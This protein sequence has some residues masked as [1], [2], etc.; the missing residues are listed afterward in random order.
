MSNHDLFDSL[1][2]GNKFFHRDFTFILWLFLSNRYHII[3]HFLFSLDSLYFCKF[4][5][6]TLG[7][8]K[9]LSDGRLDLISTDKMG[10]N[11][12]T[13]LHAYGLFNSF[14]GGHKLFHRNFAFIHRLFL[15]LRN[16]IIYH[17]LLSFNGLDL[18]KF[19]YE[20]IDLLNSLSE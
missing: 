16:H 19:W 10:D 8:L 15:S 18:S 20:T 5:N 3:Y 2:S 7:L 13:L 12:K 4:W 9:C 14:L 6:E 1:L 11:G 17:F